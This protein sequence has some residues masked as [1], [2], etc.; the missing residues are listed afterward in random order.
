M[1]TMALCC[2]RGGSLCTVT[3]RATTAGL[4]NNKHT[5][6]LYASST[7]GSLTRSRHDEILVSEVKGTHAKEAAWTDAEAS[8]QL[9][10]GRSAAL[11]FRCRRASSAAS[12]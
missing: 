12:P 6:Q 9:I 7:N 5:M 11:T 8:T 10:A 3:P 2:S 4:R 1:S